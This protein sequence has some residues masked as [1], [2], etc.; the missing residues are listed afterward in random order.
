MAGACCLCAPVPPVTCLLCGSRP[1][2]REFP[3]PSPALPCVPRPASCPAHSGVRFW[4]TSSHRPHWLQPSLSPDQ[5]AGWCHRFCLALPETQQPDHRIAEAHTP[6]A[7]SKNFSGLREICQELL[8]CLT[9]S[10]L[11]SVGVHRPGPT[12]PRTLPLLPCALGLGQIGH[13]SAI[14]RWEWAFAPSSGR[15]ASRCPLSLPALLSS[16][17]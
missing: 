2:R 13:S 4:V 15:L 16:L 1:G 17:S 10:P 6:V 8:P 9:C 5:V 12:D 14:A 3:F 7:T 11:G